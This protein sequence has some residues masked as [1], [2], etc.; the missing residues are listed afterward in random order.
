MIYHVRAYHKQA[1]SYSV[2][3]GKK[4]KGMKSMRE[5]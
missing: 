1:V 2:S 3:F 4:I 5:N